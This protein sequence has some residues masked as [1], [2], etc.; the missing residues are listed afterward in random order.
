MAMIPVIVHAS[1][2]M[3][4][5]LYSF[6]SLLTLDGLRRGRKGKTLFSYKLAHPVHTFTFS[7]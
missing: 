1:V 7:F 2:E 6:V 5:N 3:S 4:D